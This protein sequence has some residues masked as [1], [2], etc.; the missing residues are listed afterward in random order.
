MVVVVV[1]GKAYYQVLVLFVGHLKKK[2]FV[3]SNFYEKFLKV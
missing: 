1:S 2:V 3:S